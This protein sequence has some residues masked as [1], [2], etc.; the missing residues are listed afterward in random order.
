MPATFI[1]IIKYQK[2]ITVLGETMRVYYQET[3]FSPQA[4]SNF[5]AFGTRCITNTGYDW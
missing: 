2:D 3:V 4:Q 1:N 5:L